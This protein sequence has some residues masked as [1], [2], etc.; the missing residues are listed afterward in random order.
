MMY[1]TRV[2]FGY[3]QCRGCLS[4]WIKEVP[5][6][7][8]SFYPNDYYSLDSPP[9]ARGGW[10]TYRLM[11]SRAYH[12]LSERH[13]PWPGVLSKPKHLAWSAPA[14]MTRRARILDVGCGDGRLLRE[15]RSSGF[16][17]LTGIDPFVTHE[18]DERGLRIVAGT[19]DDAE[20]D[21]DVIMFHHSLEHVADPEGT[22]DEAREHLNDSGRIVVRMPLVA[23]AWERYGPDWVQLDAPRHLA[24]YSSD[25]FR[26]AVERLGLRVAAHY[27]DS[28][29]FQFWGSEQYR[30]DIPLNSSRSLS[31]PSHESIF[32]PWE[33]AAWQYEAMAL[34]LRGMGDQGVFVL[35]TQ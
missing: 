19:L 8:S 7:L 29:A 6:D 18:I 35:S 24:L 20:R 11:K 2:E 3:E 33:V 4:M 28:S 31:E 30:R 13:I 14:L 23:E 26:Q 5:E 32:E 1:G 22:L 21:Y 34:N 10:E 16:R 25:G 27:C 9:P 17:H 15:L 12:V